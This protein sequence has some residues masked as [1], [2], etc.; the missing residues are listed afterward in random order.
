MRN[1]CN[2]R[3]KTILKSRK[4]FTLVELIVVLVILAILA[5]ILVPQ[6]LGWIDNARVKQDMINARNCMTAMQAELT[7]MYAFYKEGQASGISIKDKPDQQHATVFPGVYGTNN[8]GDV[9]INGSEYAKKIL[10][11]ADEDP[12]LFVVGMGNRERYDT[13]NNSD[14]HKAYTCYVAIYMKN[15]DSTPLYFDGFEWTTNY[16]EKDTGDYADPNG[17]FTGSGNL[18][19]S[20]G[21]YIQYYF[22]ANKTG[23]TYDGKGKGSIWNHL[24]TLSN[25]KKKK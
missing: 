17:V 1:D 25:S 4:G 21:I 14:L 13:G 22:V 6:L 5:A 20:T 9:A 8:N 3:T 15:E 10:D 7:K 18:M 19:R 16:L 12:Y 24:R 2:G 11:T 23:Y